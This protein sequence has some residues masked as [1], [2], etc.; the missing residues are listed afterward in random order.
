MHFEVLVEDKSGKKML[1]ILF[2]KII[3]DNTFKVIAYKG[4]G[5]IPKNLKQKADPSKRI[6]LNNLPRLLRGYGNTFQAYGESYPAAVIVI[7]DLDN[8]NLD[9]F[10]KELN[11]ILNNCYPKP[12]TRFCF[13][14]EEGEAWFL[15]DIEAIKRAYPDAKDSVLSSY[16]N[17]SICGTWEVLAEAIYPGGYAALSQKQ[18]YEIGAEKSKWSEKIT[19][20]MDINVNRSPSFKYLK[21]KLKELI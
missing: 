19:P 21:T 5:H 13:S 18:W 15:G 10:K 16:I 4:I 2:P 14:I 7:C 11:E 8:K 20:Y 3:G 12:E 9:E 6:F 17:D 1:D